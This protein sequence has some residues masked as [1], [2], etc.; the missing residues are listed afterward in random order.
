MSPLRLLLELYRLS[1]ER[2]KDVPDVDIK[3]REEI[4]QF[5]IP[6]KHLPEYEELTHPE[7]GDVV[8]LVPSPD[9]EEMVFLVYEINE[10]MGVVNLMP[11]S[12]WWE[13]ATDKDV[14]VEVN[15]KKYIVQPGLSLDFPLLNFSQRFGDRRLFR[16]GKLEEKYM[17]K[18]KR[19][20]RG[21]EKGDGRMS[22]G[23]KREFKRL[24]AQRYLP[25]FLHT[26]REEEELQELEHYLLSYRQQVL[27]A[28]GQEQSWG[29]KEGISWV[30]DPEEEILTLV[31][32]EELVGKRG[33][34]TLEIEGKTLTLYEG[35]LR[36]EI[37]IPVSKDAYSYSALMEGL[38]LAV[39]E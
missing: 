18:V 26:L 13:F 35:V 16:I 25:I 11:M 12:K 2:P 27:A 5:S 28:A 8:E 3:E 32:S 36:K 19:V 31:I 14:L 24:E 23:V 33:R 29:D 4:P 39:S 7:E 30:Y 10:E 20:V 9:W 15:G 17:E 38:N 34:I 6:Q 37:K 1:L 22:G 21:E